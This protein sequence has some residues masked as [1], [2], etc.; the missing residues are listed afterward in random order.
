MKRKPTPLAC[1]RLSLFLTVLAAAGAVQAQLYYRVD[2]GYSKS[3]NADFKDQDP[4]LPQICAD[5]PCT[6]P[7]TLEKAVGSSVILSAGVGRR[8]NPNMRADV[9][10]GYR[11]GYKLDD[12]EKS[13]LTSHFKAD[14]KSLALMANVYRDFPL[15]AWTP[16]AGAGLGVA[17]NKIGTI[18]L[19]LEDGSGSTGTAPGGTKTGLAFALMAGAGIRL[20]RLTLDVGYRFIDLG[21]IESGAGDI[22]IDGVV[23]TP[24]YAGVTGKLRA[25][26]LTVGLRF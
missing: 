19:S 22:I 8:F 4:D 18:S 12:T 26:E 5:A 24:P 10:L 11:G 20:G 17:L 7:G 23:L 2:T 25:H 16:Y 13:V 6:T 21:K 9:T 1:F 15:A 3:L 14:A